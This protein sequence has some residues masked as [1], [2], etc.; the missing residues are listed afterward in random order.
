MPCEHLIL[1]KWE[2]NRDHLGY[3]YQ[4]VKCDKTFYIEEEN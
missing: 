1:V 4:C 2:Y 3:T